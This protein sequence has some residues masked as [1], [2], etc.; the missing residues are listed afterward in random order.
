M[1]TVPSRQLNA[2][3]ALPSQTSKKPTPSFILGSNGKNRI[4]R[5]LS[6]GQDKTWCWQD[7]ALAYFAAGDK[8]QYEQTLEFLRKLD[9][10]A[11]S[12]TEEAVSKT[13]N[14]RPK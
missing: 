6:L 2:I 9:E 7:I 5:S 8:P 14:E 11:A 4:K 12:E 13:R 10:K 1:A 3:Y